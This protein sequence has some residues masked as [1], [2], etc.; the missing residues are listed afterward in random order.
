MKITPRMRELSKIVT[1]LQDMEITK[2]TVQE[3][4]N[5]IG[6]LPD[7]E[8]I[9]IIFEL[10]NRLQFIIGSLEDEMVANDNKR[11][12]LNKIIKTADMGVH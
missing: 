4:S 8:K 1:E 9:Q 12:L 2:E 7:H 11:K 5:T 6:Q 10:T 3:M